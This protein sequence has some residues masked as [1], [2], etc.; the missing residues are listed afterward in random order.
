MVHIILQ[1]IS[2]C[3]DIF[4]SGG[5]LM[6]PHPSRS[7]KKIREGWDRTEANMPQGVATWDD[8]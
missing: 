3:S 5:N 7:M 4:T 8:M 1:T 6:A 2:S